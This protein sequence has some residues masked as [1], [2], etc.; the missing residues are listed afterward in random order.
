[1]GTAWVSAASVQLGVCEIRGSSLGENKAVCG[2]IVVKK[3]LLEANRLLS[4]AENRRNWKVY[5]H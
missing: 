5:Q 3:T 1:M 4:C 2:Q